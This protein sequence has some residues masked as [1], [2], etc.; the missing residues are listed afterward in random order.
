MKLIDGSHLSY[1]TNVHAGEGW[2]EA[3]AAL[4]TH[5]PA[6]REALRDGAP[7]EP[8]GLGLRLSNDSLGEL[9]HPAALGAFRAWL[10][11]SGCYVFTIN[12]FPYGPFHG[13]PV[14][15]NV[16]RPD[17]ADAR[18]LDY[19]CRLADI[20]AALALPGRRIT[21]STLPG[22]YKPWANGAS[23]AI[24][25]HLL[26]AAAHCLQLQRR[27]GA[28]IG[29]AVEPEPCCLLESA[30]EVC[31]FF[32]DWLHSD[33]ATAHVARRAAVSLAVAASGIRHHL[34]VCH[35][36]CHSAVAFEPPL[37]A[38]ER[39]AQAG[40]E[41]MK[42]QLSS[43]LRLAPADAS[44]RAALAAFDEPVYLHQVVVRTADGALHR[45]SDIA[46]ALAADH[47]LDSEW[48][49]HFHVPVFLDELAAFGTT[50]AVLGELL[51]AHARSPLSTHLE[52]ETYTWDVLPA[53]LRD[54]PVA[55]AI[56]R[57][58]GWVR[59][60]LT[61][62]GAPRATESSGTGGSPAQPTKTVSELPRA[63]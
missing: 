50:Q 15:A 13:T 6:V 33:A 3:F 36:V 9:E 25:A 63:A 35:D 38:I 28:D 18:R 10:N 34:G 16:Y 17:W 11:D 4:R 14:K 59:D 62:A 24:A 52:V 19:T 58:L 23:P 48:R 53:A 42:V 45:H 20:A 22:T 44:A 32:R 47:A 56:A 27:T 40:V 37:A 5:V 41:V 2:D 49:V 1:C 46:A 8:F 55:T 29:I 21:I 60:R 61:R 30:D 57:E 31:D 26:D 39:Y 54:V 51:D 12:G 7:D 43:A